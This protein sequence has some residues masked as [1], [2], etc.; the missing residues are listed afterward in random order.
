MNILESTKK[1]YY[2][3]V[4]NPVP[5]IVGLQITSACNLRCKLC[6][7]SAGEALPNELTTSETKYIISNLEEAKV[8]HLSFGGG[9]PLVRSDILELAS[10]AS[11]RISSVGIVSNGFIID[12]TMALKIKDAGVRQVMISLDGYN[13]ETHDANRGKGSYDRALSALEHIRNEQM[14]ARISFT[15]SR[16]NAHQLPEIIRLAQEL[17]VSLNVQEFF[18]RGR[19]TGQDDLILTRRQRKEM[20]RILF[21]NQEDRGAGSV[22]FENRYII[23]EDKKSLEICTNPNLGSDFYDFCVG[24]LTGIYSLFVSSTGEVRLCGRHGEGELG[25]LKNTALSDIW[26]NSEFLRKV[27]D[28]ESLSG[29]CGTCAYRY[30]CG[31]CRRNALFMSSDWF[32]EDPLCW[33]G[34]PEDEL[35]I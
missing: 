24:C 8:I 17:D 31:G 25:N 14:S 2:D 7:A 28:R 12:R 20:Q 19:A 27:R 5:M 16:S 21:K 32:A 13:A 26:K 35:D 34:R 18:A 30:V 11:K 4:K 23:S 22:G 33:R 6:G 10:Y 9:E 15:I 3:A 1:K 29:R